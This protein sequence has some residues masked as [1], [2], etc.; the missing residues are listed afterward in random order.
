MPRLFSEQ[1][2]GH[3]QYTRAVQAWHVLVNAARQRCLLTYAELSVR[4]MRFTE[5]RGEAGGAAQFLRLIERYCAAEGLPHMTRI[6]VSQ[7]EEE[8]TER[9]PEE[10]RAEDPAR[11][12]NYDWL[13][14]VP[15]TAQDFEAI[16]GR[17]GQ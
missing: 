17:E 1:T 15:P 12:F 8:P 13:D 11:V 16:E 7:N 3:T 14:V 10:V 9:T 5:G 6:V 2:G 4:E